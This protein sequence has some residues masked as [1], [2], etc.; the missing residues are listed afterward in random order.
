MSMI[1]RCVPVSIY[2]N[3]P[4]LRIV[5][6]CVARVPV[7]LW[8][9]GGWGCV[10]SRLLNRPQPSATVRN[11]SQPSAWWPYGRAY[12]KFCRRGRFWRFHMWCC[13]VLRGRRGT[14]WH[15]DVFCN[16]SKIVLCGRRNTFTTS[17]EDALQFSWQAQHFGR[18]HRHFAWQAQHFIDVSCCVFFANR[19]GRAASSGDKVQIPWQAWH[20][21]RYAE[22]WRKPRTKHWFW[23]SKF[24]GS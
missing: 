7:S 24:R 3:G 16:V 22:N 20:F 21:V 5:P 14:S 6:E 13:F 15:S 10:R 1:Y 9:S 2:S 4:A 11:C 23:G 17:S 19:I 18:V 8:R 12:G